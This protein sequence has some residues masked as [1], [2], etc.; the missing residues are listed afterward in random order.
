M[1]F[2]RTAAEIIFFIATVIVASAV[3][4]EFMLR[5]NEFSQ[6][7]KQQGDLLKE[8]I[9]HEIKIINDPS[10]IRKVKYEDA[11]YYV[12]YIK[13]IGKG[14]ILFNKN[15][16]GVYIDGY[17]IDEE[18]LLMRRTGEIKEGETTEVL[19]DSSLWLLKPGEHKIEIILENGIKDTL[20]FIIK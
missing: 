12:F 15:N 6:I 3:A 5:T 10:M 17:R 20:N 4:G 2:G 13:N 9:S 11:Y 8:K 16:V 19:I 7:F 14:N 1:A 18:N